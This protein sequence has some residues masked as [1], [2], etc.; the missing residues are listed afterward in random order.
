M[1]KSDVSAVSLAY[2]PKGYLAQHFY[3]SIL[4][5]PLYGITKVPPIEIIRMPV[6]ANA[7]GEVT[8]VQFDV[9]W[10]FSHGKAVTKVLQVTYGKL[11]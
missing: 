9:V 11:N 10:K 5:F 7:D 8:I 6:D 1:Y 4:P 3:W 2:R